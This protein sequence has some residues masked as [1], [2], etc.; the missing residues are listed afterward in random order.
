MIEQFVNKTRILTHILQ[1]A[2]EGQITL[3][4][5]PIGWDDSGYSYS[6]SKLYKGM[7]RKYAVNKLGFLDEAKIYIEK[8]IETQGFEAEIEYVVLELDLSTYS[9]FELFRGNLKL[10][11]MKADDIKINVPIVDSS[12]EDKLLSRDEVSVIITKRSPD[13]NYKDLDNKTILGYTNE[14][15]IITLP[16]ELII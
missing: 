1:N 14:K 6:R 3:G 13:E 15:Q 5:A 12:F 2:S 7:L 9:K 8:I 16:L 10:V 4:H 11:K